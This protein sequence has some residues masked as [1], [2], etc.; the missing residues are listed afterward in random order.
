MGGAGLPRYNYLSGMQLGRLAESYALSLRA[1]NKSEQTVKVYLDAI[2]GLTRHLG[3]RDISEISRDDVRGFIQ[4]VLAV[5][6]PYTALNRYRSLKT[7]F[8]WAVAE[9]ELETSPMEGL[10]GPRVPEVAIEVVTDDELRK[11]FAACS[12]RGFFERRD[13]AILR[14]LASTGMRAD[15]CYRLRL[16]DL[17][18][19]E[20]EVTVLGKGRRLR[21]VPF[22]KKTQVALDRYQ[23]VRETHKHADEP[24]LWLSRHGALS[25]QGLGLIVRRR[26]ERAGIPNLHPHRLRHSFADSCLR[27]GMQEGDLMRLAGW[28]S[29]EMLSRYGASQADARAF[30]SYRRL[31]PADRL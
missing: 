8:R 10:K 20:A 23:R 3:D 13:H 12:G 14:L 31:S 16:I 2:R 1:E 25:Y 21:T 24:W 29:R 18:L 15:E 9:E 30:E 7:F 28:R 22:G 17:D 27:A 19:A 11:L 6:K 5:N 4:H 26:G